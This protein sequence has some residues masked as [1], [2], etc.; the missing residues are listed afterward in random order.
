MARKTRKH[1]LKTKHKWRASNFIANRGVQRVVDFNDL[2]PSPVDNRL[3]LSKCW[4]FN[5]KKFPDTMMKTIIGAL[6][7][8]NRFIYTVA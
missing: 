7:L 2:P 1:A 8:K 4:S 5:N 6:S 3:T